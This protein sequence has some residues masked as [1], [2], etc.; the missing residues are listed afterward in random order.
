MDT[1]APVS[2]FKVKWFHVI[3][4]AFL[5][6]AIELLWLMYNTYVPVFA[7][8]GNPNFDAGGLAV[9]VGFGLGP[10]LTGFILT[11][12]NIAGLFISPLVGAWSDTIRT[13]F[14]RRMPFIIATAPIAAL[15][16]LAIPYIHAAIPPELSGQPDK[17]MNLLIPFVAA[18]FF[19]L[20]PL[21]IFRTPADTILFDITPSKH[22]ATA[23][24]IAVLVGGLVVA[25]GA[26]G[27]SALY[28]TSPYLP[29][30]VAS[31]MCL[32]LVFL[33]FVFIREPQETLEKAHREVGNLKA[34]AAF[35]RELPDENRRS[36]VFL[37]L[38]TFFG[39]TALG[40]V[41]AFLSSWAVTVLKV[42]VAQAATL[43]AITAL[44]LMF[45]AI[46][47]ALV[48][49]RFGRRLVVILGYVMVT[50]L[51]VVFFFVSSPDLA[52]F[53]I[54]FTGI[55]WAAVNVNVEPMML[56]ASGSDSVLGTIVGLRQLV[57]TLGF[58]V[59]PILG[60]GLVELMGSDYRFIW[61][62]MAVF[63][64]LGLL[65][66]LPVKKGEAR[67]ATE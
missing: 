65:M 51:S 22:R 50:V 40:Q 46:P 19:V 35:L 29:F 34:I 15:A 57:V 31:G 16:L 44:A 52:M 25:A 20:V 7:Q 28:A 1:A 60:G 8:Y 54:L 4:A 42:E 17:L 24:G 38:S 2:Q 64:F 3:L 67:K 21:A 23:M 48:A 45:V 56:D 47:W 53:L 37:A 39:F 66:M 63:F 6:A 5:P 9:A 59:G 55:G 18:L 43:Q 32:V 27:G 41:Q 33:A 49:N 62:E 12:D 61:L 10:T 14:G 13:R 36:L 11:F 58:V 30:W 26:I